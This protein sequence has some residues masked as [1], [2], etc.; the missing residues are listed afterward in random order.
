MAWYARFVA[1]FRASWWEEGASEKIL[2]VEWD[3]LRRE[4]DLEED[5]RAANVEAEVEEAI[6][7]QDAS[8]K[9]KFI[10]H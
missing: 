3:L 1:I 10:C 9:W 7:R 6:Y 2:E 5:M 4:K 8:R